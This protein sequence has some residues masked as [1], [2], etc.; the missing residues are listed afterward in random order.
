MLKSAEFK[1]E[2]YM[3]INKRHQ[4]LYSRIGDEFGFDHSNFFKLAQKIVLQKPVVNQSFLSQIG[5]QVSEPDS[6]LMVSDDKAGQK[7]IKA[8]LGQ[9][10]G[11]DQPE[12]QIKKV[13]P[14]SQKKFKFMTQPG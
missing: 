5:Y 3:W 9:V 4:E 6:F 11:F 10:F 2:G 12:I 1:Q 13:D 7:N 8:E 14:G